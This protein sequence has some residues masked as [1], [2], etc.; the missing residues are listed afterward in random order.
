MLNLKF[1]KNKNEKENETKLISVP[2]YEFVNKIKP[3]GGILFDNNSRYYECGDG[4][5]TVLNVYDYPSENLPDFWLKDLL[6]QNYV[7]SFLAIKTENAKDVAKAI[8]TS[9]ENKKTNISPNR[10]STDNRVE[11]DQI[12]DLSL[13]HERI[14]KQSMGI[15]AIAI[16]LFVYAPTLELLE[17][18]RKKI[19]EEN[20]LFKMTTLLDQQE[21][22]YR[23]AFTPASKIENLPNHRSL[24]IIPLPDL[25]GGYFFDHIKLEDENGS[26]FGTTQTGGAV[27]FDFQKRDSRRTR[28]FMFVSGN[29]NSGA[30]TFSTSVLDDQFSRGHFI[31]NFNSESTGRLNRYT[32]SIGGLVIDMSGSENRINPMQVFPTSMFENGQVD[33]VRSM[34]LHIEKLQNM[35][36]TLNEEASGDDKNNFKELLTDFYCQFPN[37][38]NPLWYNNPELHLS[39]L[40]ATKIKNEE[41]PILSDFIAYLEGILVIEGD[42]E[43]LKSIRRI[44]NTFKTLLQTR[45]TMFE[46]HTI[47]QNISKTQVV[48]FDLSGLVEQPQF[49]NV[50]LFNAI[51]MISGDILKRGRENRTIVRTDKKQKDFLSN[52]VLYINHIDQIIS[53]R[54]QTAVDLFKNLLD[55]M[56]ENGAGAIVEASS[57]QGMI[58][59]SHQDTYNPYVDS[60]NKIF[61]MMNYRVFA[62]TGEESKALLA[63]ALESSLNEYELE[64]LPNLPQSM[65]LMNIKGT[66]NIIFEQDLIEDDLIELNG[67]ADY[68]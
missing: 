9:I 14:T 28:S 4:F 40:R 42:S 5:V 50:Q 62:Q 12:E 32:R 17:E 35:F 43:R 8:S 51:S 67:V 21:L 61:E 44:W 1:G 25:A 11:F 55:K 60:V 18:R 37:S 34:E 57:I 13:I 2:D 26:Y 38:N 15:K 31:R 36:V 66:K 22:E 6:Q 3:Q 47:F 24:R 54:Y 59:Q 39:E 49:Y 7:I 41:Y 63:T 45:S 46:G 52:Y 27:L 33:E 68:V 30:T 23:L 58:I 16:P 29:P 10:K 48:T 64:S 20:T 56:G 19:I 65:L 53:P